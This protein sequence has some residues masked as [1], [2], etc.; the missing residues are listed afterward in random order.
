[1]IQAAIDSVSPNGGMILLKPATYTLSSSLVMRSHV[2]LKG[3]TR[4]KTILKLDNGVN[5]YV[6][7]N[8]TGESV[9]RARLENLWINGN[10]AN[11]PAGLSGIGTDF[12]DT[13]IFNCEVRNCKEHGIYLHPP[14]LRYGVDI[15]F[16]KIDGCDIDGI[17]YQ[18]NIADFRLIQVSAANCGRYGIDIEGAVFKLAFLHIENSQTGLRTAWC[19][20]GQISHVFMHGMEE[21]GILLDDANTRMQLTGPIEIRNCSKKL[22]NTYHGIFLDGTETYY[23][24][25]ITIRGVTVS[26]DG[27]YLFNTCIK[28]TYVKNA[29]VEHN[30]L[31]PGVFGTRGIDITGTDIRIRRNVGFVTEN[32][33]VA[34]FSGDGTTTVFNIPHGLVS[35]PRVAWVMAESDDARGDKKVTRGATN[36]TV[37]F[38]TAPPAGTDNVVLGWKAEV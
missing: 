16:S 27:T 17:W 9:Y 10:K 12:D 22:S 5:D 21:H 37:T 18:G 25:D 35:T 13:V 36:I 11:N 19:S 32:D 34:T 3:E 8:P 4:W 38:A 1:V 31:L 26:S 24:E 33:G 15:F 30:F 6:I 28:G 14:S 2:W 20:A 23:A 7:K 29:V